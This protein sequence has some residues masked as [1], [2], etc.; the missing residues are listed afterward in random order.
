MTE[1]Q[2]CLKPVC[3][4]ST[5]HPNGSLYTVSQD[6]IESYP[7]KYILYRASISMLLILLACTC[8]TI[9]P[10]QHLYVRWLAHQ[11]H[12]ISAAVISNMIAS[13]NIYRTTP[14]EFIGTCMSECNGM[15]DAYSATKAT[16]S[17]TIQHNMYS[18][19]STVC[20]LTYYS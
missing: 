7:H 3:L 18:Q 11:K 5:S 12:N 10:V 14:A 19:Y 16:S 17:M 15:C 4:P 2:Q 8:I 6:T 13:A 9:I 1:K 20:I